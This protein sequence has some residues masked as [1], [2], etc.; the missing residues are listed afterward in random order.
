METAHGAGLIHRRLDI[1]HTDRLSGLTFE[2]PDPTRARHLPDALSGFTE[3]VEPVHLF[4]VP[5]AVVVDTDVRAGLR[6]L[7]EDRL[8]PG[9]VSAAHIPGQVAAVPARHVSNSL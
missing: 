3:L 6:R 1:L 9:G 7:R 8:G 5:V 4:G 2:V